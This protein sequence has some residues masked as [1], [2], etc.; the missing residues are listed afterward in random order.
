L[1][2]FYSEFILPWFLQFGMARGYW[3]D[4]KNVPKKYTRLSQ[5]QAGA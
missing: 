4:T 5:K 2:Y 3:A 1:E